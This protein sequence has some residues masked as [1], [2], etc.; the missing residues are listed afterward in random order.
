MSVEAR[1]RR[2]ALAAYGD[3]Y[4]QRSGLSDLLVLAALVDEAIEAATRKV[5]AIDPARARRGRPPD[6]AA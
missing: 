1:F 5:V 6:G 4:A 2:H 3:A